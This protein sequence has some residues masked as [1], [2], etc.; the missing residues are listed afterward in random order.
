[1][2]IQ[3]GYVREQKRYSK[4][5][6]KER[7]ELNNSEFLQFVKKLKAYG[8]L[9]MVKDT[10][11]QKDLSDLSDDDIEIVDVDYNDDNYLYVFTYVGILTI[12]KIVVKCFPKYLNKEKPLEEMKEI[13][14][15]V[16]KYNNS[17]Q[18]IIHLFNG[19]DKQ[20]EFNLLAIML[21]IIRD[22][23]ENGAYTNQKEIVERNGDGEILWDKTINETMALIINNRPFY[24]ELLTRNVMDNESDYM[25][26]LHK[27]IVTECC[28]RLKGVD[29]LE[30]FGL[31]EIN[32]SEAKRT[33]FGENNYILY[34]IKKEL[35]IQFVTQKQILLKTLYSYIAFSDSF[36]ENFGLSMYGTNSFNLVWENACAQVFDNKLGVKLKDLDLPVELHKEY[37]NKKDCSLLEIIE[38][39]V[40][41]PCSA[42]D[43]PHPSERTLIPDL[44]SIYK[45]DEDEWHFG[46]FDAKYY[47]IILDRDK[48]Q[49]QPGVGDVTK[50]HLYQL[51]YNDFIEKHRFDNVKNAFLMPTENDCS[52]LVGKVEM[53]IFKEIQEPSFNKILVIKLSARHIFNYYL[54][55]KK[56]DIYQELNLID[57]N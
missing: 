32:I 40:W 30:I 44:I 16:S 35:N 4:S 49:N 42:E 46:I 1:M 47:N 11:N 57:R 26:R 24:T 41:T 51:A 43:K 18:Q 56:L 14:R 33:D 20:R 15:V 36:R 7:F 37:D 5:D 27:C 29:L 6:L 17:K 2:K 12:G 21:Y 55:G 3:S 39:P 31:N 45:N 9:K 50:Q 19:Y 13:L 10:S 52:E 22:F 48:L 23:N 53:P 38:K 54:N 25:S 34:M 28:Q 8:V